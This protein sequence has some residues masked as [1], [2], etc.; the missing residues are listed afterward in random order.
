MEEMLGARYR[1]GVQRAGGPLFPNLHHPLA[2]ELLLNCFKMLTPMQSQPGSLE[3]P[4]TFL[5]RL[6]PPPAPPLSGTL[7]SWEPSTQGYMYG[8]YPSKAAR[9]GALLRLHIC[10][11]RFLRKHKCKAKGS[12]GLFTGPQIQYLLLEKAFGTMSR[13]MSHRQ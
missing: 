1:E 8:R 2:W 11:H 4:T 12:R 7:N 9:A 6:P 5:T 10:T 3:F 13:M